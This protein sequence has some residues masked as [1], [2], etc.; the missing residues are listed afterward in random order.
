MFRSKLESSFLGIIATYLL[1]DYY[2]NG[3]KIG[4]EAGR[5]E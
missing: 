1:L 4:G 5:T 2:F 3:S